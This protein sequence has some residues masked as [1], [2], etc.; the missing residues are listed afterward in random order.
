MDSGSHVII[1]FIDDIPRI[2]VIGALM[3]I[4]YRELSMLQN[5]HSADFRVNGAFS[6]S[7]SLSLNISRLIQRNSDKPSLEALIIDKHLLRLVE[8]KENLLTYIFRAL[9]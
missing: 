7:E 9:S 1:E 6:A 2:R 5:R 8:G 4:L 3:E